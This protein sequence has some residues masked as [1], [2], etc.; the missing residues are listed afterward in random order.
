MDKRSTYLLRRASW[1]NYSLDSK[2]IKHALG[3][4]A[5]LGTHREE[6]ILPADKYIIRTS[7]VANHTN[8]VQLR[9]QK[10][11]SKRGN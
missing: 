1:R 10:H 2:A 5:L 9:S 8:K 3:I 11:F 6:G 7:T 4:P